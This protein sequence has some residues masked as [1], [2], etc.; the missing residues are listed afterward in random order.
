MTPTEK[1]ARAREL[2]ALGVCPGCGAPL[3]KVAGQGVAHYRNGGVVLSLGRSLTSAD[4]RLCP[5]SADRL[6]AL[7]HLGS[8]LV[9][10]RS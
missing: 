1:I 6:A 4:P 3:E 8:G 10:S 2:Y 7:V 9:G 5:W